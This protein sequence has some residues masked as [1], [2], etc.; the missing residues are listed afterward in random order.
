MPTMDASRIEQLKAELDKLRQQKRELSEKILAWE[1]AH[2][3]ASRKRPADT[4][5]EGP[6]AKRAAIYKNREKR[7]QGIFKQCETIVKAITKSTAGKWFINDPTKLKLQNYDHWV[8]TPM[9]LGR[10]EERLRRREYKDVAAFRDD[11]RLIFA[12]AKAYNPEHSE[13]R[14]DA[15]TCSDRFEKDYMRANL[16]ARWAYEL[17]LQAQEQAE[18]AVRRCAAC[19]VRCARHRRASCRACVHRG[20]TVHCA[21]RLPCLLSRCVSAPPRLLLRRPWHFARARIPPL[22]MLPKPKPPLTVI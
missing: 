18:L 16:E 2:P 8:K 17:A 12:N 13:A 4:Q 14:R 1:A 10:V 21:P 22:S 19:V 20:V 6:E 9:W 5:M 11:M 15:E 7:V 3:S